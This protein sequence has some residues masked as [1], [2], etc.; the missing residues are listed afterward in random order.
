MDVVAIFMQSIASEEC[1]PLP[2]AAQ[3]ELLAAAQAGDQQARNRLARS[4]LRYVT[5]WAQRY[6]RRGLPLLDL[7]TFTMIRSLCCPLPLTIACTDRSSQ[8]QL[9][10]N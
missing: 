10:I 7:E 4:M 2:R 8:I 6:S 9:A 3:R 1:R 5:Q